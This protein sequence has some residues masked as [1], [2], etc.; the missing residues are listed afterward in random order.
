MSS[1]RLTNPGCHYLYPFC[2]VY[3]FPSLQFIIHHLKTGLHRPWTVLSNR[4]AMRTVNAPYE[5]RHR[6]QAE[7]IILGLPC[8]LKNFPIPNN[9]IQFRNYFAT[10]RPILSL[11]TSFER[12]FQAKILRHQLQKQVHGSRHISS[13]EI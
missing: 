1:F 11:L 6:I 10:S 2:Y 3:C 5:D 4:E 9:L 8:R 12:L 7:A 13:C